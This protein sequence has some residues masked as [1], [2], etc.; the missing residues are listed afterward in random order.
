M[1]QDAVHIDSTEL[2]LD[3]TVDR[4]LEAAFTT[5]ICWDLPIVAILGRPNVGKSTFDQSLYWSS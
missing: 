4:H 1:A 5:F 2:T 3:E